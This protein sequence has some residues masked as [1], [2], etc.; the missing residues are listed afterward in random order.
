VPKHSQSN[1]NGNGGGVPDWFFWALAF[2]ALVIG[3]LIFMY[4][5]EIFNEG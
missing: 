1:G 5:G 3:V 2:V 4:G